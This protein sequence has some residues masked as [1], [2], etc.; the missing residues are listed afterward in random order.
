MALIGFIRKE[1]GVMR[2]RWVKPGNDAENFSLDRNLVVFDSAAGIGAGVWAAGIANLTFPYTSLTTI[3]SWSSPGYVPL[4]TMR[5]ITDGLPTGSPFF[6]P[7]DEA[8]FPGL[9]TSTGA[10]GG[11]PTGNLPTAQQMKVT[12][13]GLAI[14]M[15]CSPSQLTSDAICAW[16]AHTLPLE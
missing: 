10:S 12:T 6:F 1:S 3:A 5:W 7:D 8:F 16:V 4:V 14:Q 2:A 15:S 9:Q 13:T 11:F